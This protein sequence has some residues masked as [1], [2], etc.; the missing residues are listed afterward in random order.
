MCGATC[1][2][3]GGGLRALAVK[4]STSPALCHADAPNPWYSRDSPHSAVSSIR[5]S[6]LTG[7]TDSQ[8]ETRANSA[9]SEP[10]VRGRDGS[11]APCALPVRLPASLRGV[12]RETSCSLHAGGAGLLLERTVR[13]A[14]AETKR[15]HA[16]GIEVMTTPPGCEASR[17]G[18]VPRGTGVADP[19]SARIR[20]WL[21]G[22]STPPA[23]PPSSA[24]CL[25]PA[26]RTPH[27]AGRCR[28]RC[29]CRAE[30]LF[31]RSR[32]RESARSPLPRGGPGRP[33]CFT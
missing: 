12:S 33:R 30:P 6:S 4:P 20:R 27:P 11:A 18:A 23:P 29:R 9:R 7:A 25:L 13:S 8:V 31:P 1:E 10:I 16:L 24:R 21:E 32:P 14:T 22:D 2:L 15:T 17:E 19:E 26:P 3:I 5:E 28:C